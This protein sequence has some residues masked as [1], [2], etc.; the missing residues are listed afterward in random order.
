MEVRDAVVNKHFTLHAMLMTTISDNPAHRNLSGQSKRKGQGCSH[1]LSETC[2]LRLKNSNKFAYMGHR[3]W[4]S[5]NHPYRSMDKQFDGTR[6]TRNPPPHLSGS[7]VYKQ[8]K[9]VRTVLGKRKRGVDHEGDD[10]DHDEG[11][12]NKKSILWELEYWHILAVRHS[13]DTMHLK[14][15]ICES[16]VGTIMNTKG[17]GKDHE[18]ARSDLEDMG[19]HPELYVE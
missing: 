4:L 19:I 2:S 12:W 16:L 8:V 15:N 17:K 5:K 11:I 6:E 10:D 13:I 3:R 9:D 1:C 7:D 14:K 18:N